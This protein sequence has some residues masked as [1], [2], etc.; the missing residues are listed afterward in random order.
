M[1]IHLKANLL[2]RTSGH[3][4]GTFKKPALYWTSQSDGH[5]STFT[6]RNVSL[7]QRCVALCHHV[8]SALRSET[9]Y[10]SGVQVWISPWRNIFMNISTF[11][12]SPLSCF[13]TSCTYQA[14]TL[15]SQLYKSRDHE[16]HCSFNKIR[17]RWLLWRKQAQSRD[18]ALGTL[19]KLLNIMF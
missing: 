19:F 11:K 6:L 15:T 8:T 16:L 7:S 2:E 17:L 13:E 18:I 5:K 4:L 10:W 12:T 14:P 1:L 3:G 9:T